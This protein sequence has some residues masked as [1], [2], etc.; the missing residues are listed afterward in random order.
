LGVAGVRGPK[1]LKGRVS[2]ACLMALTLWGLMLLLAPFLNFAHAAS[3]AATVPA[4]ATPVIVAGST[5]GS[6]PIAGPGR[7]HQVTQLTVHHQG[8]FWTYGTDVP[9]YLRRLQQWSRAAKGWVD[10]PYHY[11]IGPDGTIYAGRSPTIAGDTN[12][13][14]DTQGHLQVMLLGNFEEQTVTTRQWDSTVQ[15]LAHLLKA[16]GLGATRIGAHRHHST[17]TVCPGADLMVR[18]EEL[19]Q[20]AARAV[21]R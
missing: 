20:A 16:H 11:V 4:A 17:Q 5:W 19:Q 9:A 8:E 1:R 12:T 3:G 14:Y 10:V 21:G 7:A 6:T 2:R 15:L 13:E 18:F